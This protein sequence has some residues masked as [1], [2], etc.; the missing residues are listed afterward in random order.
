MAGRDYLRP[1][2]ILRRPAPCPFCGSDDIYVTYEHGYL[3]DSAVVFCNSCKVSVKL[4]ENDQE[5][6]NGE[7]MMKAVEA[8][9]RRSTKPDTNTSL[10]NS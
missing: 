9:K 1:I 8:W 5:G 4:E 6:I 3:D 7:T 2:P 10:T